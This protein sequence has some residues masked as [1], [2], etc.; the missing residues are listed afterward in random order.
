M[1][2]CWIYCHVYREIFD[3]WML[4]FGCNLQYVSFFYIFAKKIILQFLGFGSSLISRVVDKISTSIRICSSVEVEIPAFA[5]IW[6][7]SLILMST[8]ESILLVGRSCF[9]Q[10]LVP[11]VLTVPIKNYFEKL[12]TNKTNLWFKHNT[13]KHLHEINLRKV[14]TLI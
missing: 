9:T 10:G 4:S 3:F 6:E 12:S 14:N 2:T 11:G 1:S 5:R 7:N 13:L 8:F